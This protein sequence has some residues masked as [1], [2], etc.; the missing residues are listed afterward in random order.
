ML[1]LK[2]LSSWELQHRPF[3]RL[4]GEK[5]PLSGFAALE[6]PTLLGTRAAISLKRSTCSLIEAWP[7]LPVP[8]PV[9]YV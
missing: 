6:D 4:R 8:Y 3:L 9:F 1:L 7:P 5:C 2:Q